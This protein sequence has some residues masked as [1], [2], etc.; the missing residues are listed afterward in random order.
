MKND[1]G[2]IVDTD[3]Y[4]QYKNLI[5]EIISKN[6]YN[7]VVL[8]SIEPI[9]I[10]DKFIPILPIMQAK[11]FEGNLLVFNIES[12][13]MCKD[14]INIQNIFLYTNNIFWIKTPHINHFVLKDI[15]QNISNLKVITS[16][17]EVADTY[18]SV[19][20]TQCIIINGEL[21]YDKISN[22]L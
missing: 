7:Q 9:N 16:S 19:W 2:I 8:F 18:Q 3:L 1:L 4:G 21:N 13:N 22:I 6:L 5:V 20:T 17:Q 11:F 14:F 10:S 12:V 15:Y